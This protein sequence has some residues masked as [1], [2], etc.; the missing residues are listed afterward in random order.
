[1][2]T[3]LRDLSPALLDRSGSLGMF[4]GVDGEAG[5]AEV[6][7]AEV[8]VFAV[9]ITHS[10]AAVG[11]L[12]VGGPGAAVAVSVGDGGDFDDFAAGVQAL[13]AIDGYTLHTVD[14]I[15]HDCFQLPS[16]EE[17]SAARSSARCSKAGWV[18]K[19][20]LVGDAKSFQ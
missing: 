19:I 14:S 11:A 17:H 13:P 1:M 3:R 20:R 6:V 8:A 12:G 16:K 10:A 15:Q 7:G 2:F 5:C 18:F 9:P 4:G